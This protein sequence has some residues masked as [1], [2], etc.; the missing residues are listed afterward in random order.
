MIL[1]KI[2]HSI[3]VCAIASFHLLHHI[4]SHQLLVFACS[5]TSA[6]FIL[7]IIHLC[8]EAILDAINHTILLIELRA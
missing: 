1:D 6:I 3:L 7:E 5:K 8:D 2:E 4:I